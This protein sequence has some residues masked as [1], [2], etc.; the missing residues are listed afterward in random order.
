[1]SSSRARRLR[2]AAIKWS[3][4]AKACPFE[5][6]T[7]S[8]GSDRMD[9]L[10]LQIQELTTLLHSTIMCFSANWYPDWFNIDHDA[11]GCSPHSLDGQ[12]Q[13]SVQPS[14]T[15]SLYSGEARFSPIVGAEPDDTN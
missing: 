4:Y 7:K 10:M 6:S 11:F 1:M 15:D 2:N 5:A 9:A 3:L 8:C 12:F 13:S 14:A